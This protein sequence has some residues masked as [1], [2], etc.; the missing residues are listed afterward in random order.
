VLEKKAA[1]SLKEILIGVLPGEG[2]GPDVT[3]AALEVLGEVTKV[4][5]QG[6]AVEYG[7]AIGCDSEKVS[8]CALPEDVI[9]FCQ[10]V[11]DRSGAILNGPGGSRYVYDLRKEFDLFFKISPIQTHNS[12][13]EASVVKQELLEGL[14][15]LVVR[16]NISGIYQGEPG[17]GINDAGELVVRHHFSY[18][19][20]DVFRFLR[21]AARLARTRRGHLAVVY[22]QYGVRSISALWERCARVACE[23]YG[24]TCQM[25]DVDLMAYQL[26]RQPHQYDVIA[27]PNMCGDILAD[28]AAVL[29]GSRAMS[30]SGNYT[31]KGHGVYQTNH[32]AAYDLAGK[33]MASPV[34]QILSLAM[35]L[36]HSFG[37]ET[38]AQAV[39]QGLQQVWQAG[40]RTAEVAGPGVNAIG[41]QEMARL[42]AAAAG[43]CARTLLA[44]GQAEYQ[45]AS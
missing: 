14:D 25:M 32:G 45:L 7:G 19:E 22:K 18:R 11:F 10:G 26:I 2:V 41:T 38:E 5:G 30:F 40:W 13:P 12:L 39:E 16:E 31:P 24:V 44:G 20:Q 28:L 33:D 37:L 27:A 34:G 43:E 36:R 1:P 15:L 21:A 6:V 17:E 35:M 9:G 3:R 8:G 23:E 4:T 29:L 42:V